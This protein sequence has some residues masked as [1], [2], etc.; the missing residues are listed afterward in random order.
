MAKKVFIDAGHGGVD[1]GAVDG[2][3]NDPIYTEEADRNLDMALKFGA[4]LKRS[5]IEVRYSRTGDSTLTLAER[6][7]AAN[8]WDADYFVSWHCNGGPDGATSRGI[9]VFNYYGS[10]AGKA[11]AT[12]IYNRL[13]DVSPWA[14]RGV[15]EAGFYVLKY[16]HMPAA[17]IE[18]GFV[19]NTEE[20][21]ALAQPAYRLALA[22]AAAK[23]VCA[24]LGVTYV[25]AVPE[26][27]YLKA[28]AHL[29]STDRAKYQAVADACGDFIK[30]SPTTKDSWKEW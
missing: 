5:G 7:N 9:E 10:T 1:P 4:A 24:H 29:L 3:A 16:T 2:T 19:N 13:D 6:A 15:K 26:Q 23:G 25:A 22:E 27:S 20:E 11:L 8:V 12:A 30:F 17:L 18:A 21:A 14:D 28:E